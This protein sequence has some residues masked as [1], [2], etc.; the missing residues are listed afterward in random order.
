MVWLQ[1]H[2][3]LTLQKVILTLTL[4]TRQSS[5]FLTLS[6]SYYFTL[7]ETGSQVIN[8]RCIL[9]NNS[10]TVWLIIILV[11]TLSCLSV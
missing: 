7:A 10:L 8:L 11:F 5:T 3:P 2:S 6:K 1:T 9:H 4:K